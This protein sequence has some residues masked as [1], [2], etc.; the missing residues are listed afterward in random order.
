LR[1]GVGA[2]VAVRAEVDELRL[3]VGEQHRDDHEDR[4]ADRHDRR[5]LAT[6]VGDAPMALTEE[7]VGAA[8]A[9]RGPP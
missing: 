6:A 1:S 5:L 4:A 2:G 9:D 7:G 3:L 8:G